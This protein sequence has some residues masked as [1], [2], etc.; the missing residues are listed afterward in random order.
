MKNKKFPLWGQILAILLVGVLASVAAYLIVKD[1]TAERFTVTFA[2][3]DGTVIEQKQV[4]KG[5]GTFPPTLDYDG[6][7]RGW[8]AGFNNVES[9]VEVH[10]MFYDIVEDNLFYFDSVYVKE[11]SNFTLSLY[12]AGNVNVNSGDIKLS[13][14]PDVMTYKKANANGFCSVSEEKAGEL[15]VHFSSEQTLTEKTLLA[16]LTFYAKRADAYSSEILVSTDQVM[17]VANGED[18]PADHATINNNIYFLQEVG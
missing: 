9:D 17:L 18:K 4:K 3:G 14:D 16:E 15:T 13:Y 7:F 8:S 1:R 10:P 11:G 6:V 5:K 2:Y 12:L